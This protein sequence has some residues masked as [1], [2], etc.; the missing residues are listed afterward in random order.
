MMES[1]EVVGCIHEYLQLVLPDRIT[2]CSWGSMAVVISGSI[3]SS[4]EQSLYCGVSIIE[5]RRSKGQFVAVDLWVGPWSD[6]AE[7]TAE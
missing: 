1:L 3:F 2:T 7:L 6:T 4:S 5:P